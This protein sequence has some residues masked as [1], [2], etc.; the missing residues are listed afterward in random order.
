MAAAAAGRSRDKG[1]PRV[2]VQPLEG[3]NGPALRALMSR[4]V[5]GRGYRA[6]T[7]VPRQDGTGR[8]PQLARD[9]HL[10]AF[11]TGDVEEKGKWGSVTFLV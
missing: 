1:P 6:V 7:S 3:T 4:I 11:V 5:R 2:A 9:G 10:A 8:Y